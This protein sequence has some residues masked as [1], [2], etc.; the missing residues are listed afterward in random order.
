MSASDPE[1]SSEFSACFLLHTGITT[2]TPTPS[3]VPT[4]TPTAAAEPRQGDIN[5]DDQVNEADVGQF[6]DYLALR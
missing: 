3:P 4:P 2:P 6:L 1:S 5:C